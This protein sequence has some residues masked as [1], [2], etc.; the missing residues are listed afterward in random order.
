MNSPLITARGIDRAYRSPAG[1]RTVVLDRVDLDIPTGS[2]VCLTGPSGSG[3][4]TLLHCLSGLDR[5]D[6]GQVIF[7]GVALARIDDR[8]ASALRRERMGFVFQHAE[9]LDELSVRENVLLPALARRGP[10]ARKTRRWVDDLLERLGVG[11]VAHAQPA[12][13]SGGERQRVGICRALVNRP[14]VVFADEPTGALHRDAADAV[15][16]LF[17]ELHAG[18]TTVVLVTHDPL[19]AERA[20][21]RHHLLDGRIDSDR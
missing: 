21:I 18:G 13:L 7:D 14:D 3:K 11:H 2:F 17:A 8:R 5:P 12:A 10:A 19:V 6:R 16:D 4:S 20:E 9:F 1:A 15:V